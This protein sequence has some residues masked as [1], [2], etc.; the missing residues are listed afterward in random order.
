MLKLCKVFSA[1]KVRRLFRLC[2]M[3]K[4]F[5]V[6]KMLRACKAHKTRKLCTSHKA[7]RLFTGSKVLRAWELLK[8]SRQGKIYKV[9]KDFKVSKELRMCRGCALCK[10][11][12]P[13]MWSSGVRLSHQHQG[14]YILQPGC[15]IQVLSQA[16]LFRTPCSSTVR[17]RKTFK[18][19][20]HIYYAAQSQAFLMA[21]ANPRALRG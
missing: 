5:W 16:A 15:R 19:T 2:K 8:T 14:Q 20:M 3:C 18:L 10:V 12:I 6:C 9:A 1:R 7:F 13:T 21:S 11:G 4:V 17:T